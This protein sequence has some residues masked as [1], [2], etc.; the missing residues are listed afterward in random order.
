MIKL[1]NIDDNYIISLSA[2]LHSSYLVNKIATTGQN[3]SS[4]AEMLIR[5]IYKTDTF[6]TKSIYKNYNELHDG[7]VVLKKILT[8]NTDIP[9]ITMQKYA[10]NMILI[11]KNINKINDLKYLIRKKI[12]NYQENSMMAT[13]LGDLIAYTEEIYTEH[14]G[15]IRPRVVVS[16]KKEYLEKNSSLIRALLLSGIRASFLWDYYGGSKWQLMFRRKEIL[17]KCEKFFI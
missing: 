11:Q 14:I 16:G 9:L 2:L 6:D 12:D 15:I 10:L 5:S 13:N 1:G 17:N 7:Y 4:E 3:Y 8:G